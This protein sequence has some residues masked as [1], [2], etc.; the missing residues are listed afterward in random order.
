MIFAQAPSPP[1]EW[2]G[3]SPLL[4][5]F[6]G[7]VVV[8]MGGLFPGRAVRERVVPGLALLTLLVALA[9][10][11]WQ[12]D[13]EQDL[14]AGAL[15]LDGLTLTLSVLFVAA[16]IA[17]VVLAWRGFDRVE[18]PEG[19]FYALVLTSIGGMVV[20]AAAQNFITLFLGFELLS[21]PLY[22]LCAIELRRKGSLE[23]GL[24]Y[25]VV[26]SVGSATLVYGL[27]LVYGATGSTDFA[28]VAR[29][30]T[31]NAMND[32]VLLLA[33][34]ALALAG[35]AFKASVA[36]FHQWTPDVYE[37]AP[38]PVTAFM[39]TATKAAALGVTVRFL[40][41][42]LL[43][44]ADDWA[45][46]V[47]VLAVISIV[48][49]NVGALGQSSLKRLLAWSSVAQAG[50]MLG[51]VVVGTSLGVQAVVFYLAVYLVMSLAAFAVVVARER[52]TPLGDSMEAL[53]G[54]GASRPL[55]A[56]P[57]TIAMLALAGFPMTAGFI[58]KFKLIEAT[59]QGG[60]I[61]VGVAIVI[62]SMISLAYYLKVI[63][64]M[65][66]RDAPAVEPGSAVTPTPVGAPPPGGRPALAGGSPE[67]DE[68]RVDTARRD[69]E[70]VVLAV[71]FG[72]ATLA[73]GI[74]PQPLL[75]WAAR[76]G[77][78]LPGLF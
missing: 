64:V 7:A 65:W 3:I 19:E 10:L 9:C 22:V 49:G 68:G 40:D 14:L 17:T 45:L 39:A 69:P 76:A 15:R 8:L 11:V 73:A 36:P 41:V 26:G 31:G 1:V 16:G 70:L 24:K 50:Y 59:A 20:L 78:G 29:A 12:W 58:G 13:N 18:S 53:A 57:M 62:G 47:A 37:G 2:A 5:L 43:P 63:S 6:G 75:E 21:I 27:A 77:S 71:V 28:A 35:F 72:A 4:A 67:L 34:L 74:V 61:F 30:L 44:A 56:W 25:L 55:L 46:P 54:L 32:D 60:W 51:G 42:A 23:S 33:G 52:Q 38:T 48:V 66:M